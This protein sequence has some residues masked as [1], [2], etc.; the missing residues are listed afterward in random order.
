[1]Q[2]YADSNR[3]GDMITH[4]SRSE[5][6]VFFNSVLIYWSLKKQTYCET[7]MYDSELVAMKQAT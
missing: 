6:I 4:R 5:F 7:S 3:G 2:V 1:M